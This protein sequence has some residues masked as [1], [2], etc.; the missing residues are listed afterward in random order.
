MSN[1]TETRSR[2]MSKKW[3]AALAVPVLAVTGVGVASA[4]S[5]DDDIAD[6]ATSDAEAA[7]AGQ[8]ERDGR[9]GPRPLMRMAEAIGIES[10]DLR[11]ALESG[12]TL[13]EIAEENG[14]DID[15]I[16]EDMVAE[17]AARAE[18][19]GHDDFDA[20]RLSERLTELANRSIDPSDRRPGPGHRPR[21]ASE[22][23]EELL[24]LEGDEIRDALRGGQTLAE[25][26]EEQ[27][28]SLDEL[29]S[30]I[31]DDIETRMAE[32]E[33]GLPDDFDEDELTERVTERVTSEFSGPGHRRGPGHHG[34]RGFGGPGG[35]S[36]PDGGEQGRHDPLPPEPRVWALRGR[37]RG[38]PSQARSR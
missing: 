31:V 29:V 19:Q 32:S 17:V 7:H 18:E 33:R 10:E 8:H 25:I 24:G 3:M 16:I 27:G 14:A 37:V 9:R 35:P 1:T 12:Q 26:A 6:D 11:E 15:Q 20:E 5:A 30:T 13:A 21:G 2:S 38:G 4:Q 34:P 23:V 36:G 28:V 22:A